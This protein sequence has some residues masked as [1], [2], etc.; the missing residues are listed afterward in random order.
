MS[1]VRRIIKQRKTN[2]RMKMDSKQQK[3][4]DRKARVWENRRKRWAE[5]KKD[6]RDCARAEKAIIDKFGWKDS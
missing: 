1:V 3:E 6:M 2:R 5:W 4:L